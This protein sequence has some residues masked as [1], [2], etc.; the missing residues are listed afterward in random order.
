[1]CIWYNPITAMQ[2]KGSGFRVRVNEEKKGL[3]LLRYRRKELG[4]L[5]YRRTG[6]AIP[7]PRYNSF[8]NLPGL[9]CFACL[10]I[11]LRIPRH[12]RGHGSV[13]VGRHLDAVSKGIDLRAVASPINKATSYVLL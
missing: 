5:Q 9:C 2:K 7:K 1:M 4:L 6:G 13:G 8:P 10:L 3:G 12:R 11:L